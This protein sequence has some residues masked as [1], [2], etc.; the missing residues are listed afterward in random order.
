MT[1]IRIDDMCVNCGTDLLWHKKQ[2]KK[3]K[4]YI[5]LAEDMYC[6]K[7]CFKEYQLE[8]PLTE[9]KKVE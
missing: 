4:V 7:K 1:K 9:I 6:S 5:D 3:N 2:S 8:K